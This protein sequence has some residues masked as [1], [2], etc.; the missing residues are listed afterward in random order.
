VRRTDTAKRLADLYAS[1]P[2]FTC[3][4]GCT[5]C[6]GP[7][8]FSKTEWARVPVKKTATCLDCPYAEHG[9]TIYDQ[10]PFMCR[11]FGAVDDP[12]LR[13]PHGCRPFKPLTQAQGNALTEEYIRLT[14]Q[15]S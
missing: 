6:C 13:C 2:T 14:N 11:L 15:E 12:M 10:R 8:P 3:I 5:D 4:P 7:V 1:I 9:C